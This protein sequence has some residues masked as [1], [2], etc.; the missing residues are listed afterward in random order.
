RP[1]EQSSKKPVSRF[2]EVI[3]VKKKVIQ[4]PRFSDLCGTYDETFFKK[5]FSF[6]DDIRVRERNELQDQLAKSKDPEEKEKIK[7]LLNRMTQQD[8]AG[9]KKEK[10]VEIKQKIRV[11]EKALVQDGKLPFHL[12]KS[13]RKKLELAEQ[14][15]ELKKSGKLEQYLTKKRKKNARKEKRKMP[16]RGNME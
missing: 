10:S 7:Y 4:D 6:I 5:S 12:K 16:G 15:R 8:M 3:Q 9:K 1:N 11:Q 13:E 2:R 14:Y